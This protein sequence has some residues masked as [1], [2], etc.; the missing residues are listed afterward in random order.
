M[1]GTNLAAIY[2]NDGM[3]DQSVREA[4]RAVDSD[5]SNAAAHLFLSNSYNALRDPS[6]V[7]LRY[8]AVTS[9]ELLLS[10]MLSPVGGGPLSQFVTEQEYSKMFEKD[11]VG[12]SSIFDYR[13]DGQVSE[14]VSQYGT[15]GNF[16]YA[17]D[18]DYEFSRGTRLN[19]KFSALD[20]TGTFKLQLSPADSVL[21]LMQFGSAQNGDVSQYYD[22]RTASTLNI[23]V[24]DDSGNLVPKQ[25]PN[26]PNLTA[27]SRV[28]NDPGIALL[29]W[30]HEWSPGNHTLLLLGR[31]ASDQQ[32]SAL[33][34]SQYAVYRDVGPNVSPD[35]FPLIADDGTVIP[36]VAAAGKLAGQGTVQD[37][38]TFPFDFT[39]RSKL[40]I[41]SV[42]LQQIATLG[43][44]T[45]VFGGRYKGGRIDTTATL[46]N[47]GGDPSLL[48]YFAVPPSQQNES[49]NVERVNL[50]LY[51]TWHVT[52]WLSLTGGVTYDNV[53][54]PDDFRSPPLNGRQI[55]LEK[56]SP[57]A[58]F[59]L[60]PWRGAAI[61]GMYSESI[62]GPSFDESN[63]LEPTQ[64]SGFV[65]TYRSITSESL[66]GEVAGSKF[67]ISGLTFE[68]K[69]KSRTYLGVQ[70]DRLSQSIDRTAGVFDVPQ[71]D[72]LL[73]IVPSSILAQDRYHED[74]FT[75]TLNQLIGE[76]WAFGA[77][78]RRT[79]SKFSHDI[80]ELSGAINNVQDPISL[81]DLVGIAQHDVSTLQNLNLSILYNHPC[82]F[83]A[84]AEANWYRQKNDIY[85]TDGMLSTVDD[86]GVFHPVLRTTNV[87]P[88]P[89]DFW[90]Y[91]FLAGYRFHRN[92]CEISCGVLN[93]TGR[94][95][96][97]SPVNPYQELP[98][99][100]T[101]VARVKF[102]F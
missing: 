93:L 94:D 40:E 38:Q 69:L 16:S 1:R 36:Q 55:R 84:R 35:V 87:G 92:Q 46:N 26:L 13:S 18:A 22:P 90:Q 95:Y 74:S 101:F 75:A 81:S 80:P 37:V 64:I 48:P 86:A 70:Y 49:V 63:R 78:Y 41:Y 47:Y 71:S 59:I 52:P 17:L 53:R 10:N 32:V 56:V 43:P 54:Y 68:Q 77:R 66:I 21:L 82:G 72:Q 79:V 96:Q 11:G 91:N 50:Y 28:D 25:V 60:Q 100:R 76:N 89:T 29:G 2:L 3:T 58:G 8:E 6:R 57:K 20:Y 14:T 27:H 62:T 44:Q 15:K 99:G 102:T 65:Q 7:L 97:L 23:Q 31:L 34:T 12:F 30:H 51:D 83:F 19:N 73:A 98:R 5:Y 45:F 61:R 42:D 88:A 4:V 33:Q 67:R 24:Y 9:S 85:V 39:Y